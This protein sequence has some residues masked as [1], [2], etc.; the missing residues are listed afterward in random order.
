MHGWFQKLLKSRV[1]SSTCKQEAKVT[2]KVTSD[3]NSSLSFTSSSCSSSPSPRTTSSKPTQSPPA[4]SSPLR[5]SLKYDVLVCHSSD[6]SDTEEAVRLV[7]F[8][9][10]HSLRCFLVHRDTC[11][12]GAFSTELCEAVQNSHLRALLITP[13]FLQDEWCMYVMHQALSEG[14]MSNRMLPLVYNLPHSQ[15]PQELKFR[16]Y[17]DLGKHPDQCY[18]RV[19]NTVLQYLQDMVKNEKTRLQHGQL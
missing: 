15:Y 2:Q 3:S 19:N 5:W 11:P 4:L 6:P 1:P 10:A 7:S 14:P 16:F 18:S 17:F 13:N 9:E 8:L 12:G